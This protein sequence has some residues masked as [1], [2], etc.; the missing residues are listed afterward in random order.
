MGSRQLTRR[1]YDVMDTFAHHARLGW[2]TMTG[3]TT[4]L[5]IVR[6]LARRGLVREVGLVPP[7]DGDGF[8]VETRQMRPGWVMTEAGRELM[9]LLREDLCDCGYP[10]VICRLRCKR[11]GE[12]FDRGEGRG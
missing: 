12:A 8:I 5:S 4:R 3:R 9:R 7:C 1:E 2:S 6:E 11:A 10:S